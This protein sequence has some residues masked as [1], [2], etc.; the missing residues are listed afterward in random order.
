MI[1]IL[2]VRNSY[3]LDP[4]WSRQTPPHLWRRDLRG[5]G[6]SPWQAESRLRRQKLNRDLR[7]ESR[8]ILR[9]FAIAYFRAMA[10]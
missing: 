3:A 2:S 7:N 8:A 9:L 10:I 6:L 5:G 1:G 4:R